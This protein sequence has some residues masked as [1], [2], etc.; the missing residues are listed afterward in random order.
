MSAADLRIQVTDW[1][2]P[3]FLQ[4][5]RTALGEGRSVPSHGDGIATALAVQTALRAM[6]YPRATVEFRGTA[7]DVLSGVTRWIV[8]RGPTDDVLGS[9]R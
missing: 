1:A 7:D 5:L 4:A 8:R 6:G 9:D 2:D 3:E